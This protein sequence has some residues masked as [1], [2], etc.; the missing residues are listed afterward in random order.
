MRAPTRG[1]SETLTVAAAVQ[2]RGCGMDVE[3]SLE[4]GISGAGGVAGDGVDRFVDDFGK[5]SEAQIVGEGDADSPQAVARL[6]VGG[7]RAGLDHMEAADTIRTG[8]LGQELNSESL[9]SSARLMTQ[10]AARRFVGN[11][12]GATVVETLQGNEATLGGKSGEGIEEGG[13]T[14]DDMEAVRREAGFH[15]TTGADA[16]GGKHAVE[17][18]RGAIEIGER[19]GHTD[20]HRGREKFGGRFGQ[21]KIVSQSTEGE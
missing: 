5:V 9:D 14:K 13:I 15:N 10:F 7:S 6:R 3:V 20:G 4:T 8:K 17:E 2:T 12:A 18:G 1:V 16:V 19:N 21:G 11:K